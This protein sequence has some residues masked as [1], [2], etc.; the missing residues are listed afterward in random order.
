MRTISTGFA[1]LSLGTLM[2][3]ACTYRS[4]LAADHPMD[5]NGGP[6]TGGATATGG[7]GGMGGLTSI[8]GSTSP[9][10][11][12]ST[13]GTGSASNDRGCTSDDDC[14][15]CVYASTP[16][17]PDQCE[18]A[19]GCCGGPVMNRVACARNEAAWQANCANRGYTVPVCPCII[20]CPGDSPLRCENGECGYFCR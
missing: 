4:D 5:A 11:A 14:V 10:A 3:V 2:A 12:T 9:T 13:G 18:G 15:Q 7:Q 6:Q 8:G 1:T 17:S 16:G 20:P 19:L